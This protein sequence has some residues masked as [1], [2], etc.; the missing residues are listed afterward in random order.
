MALA[1]VLIAS[2]HIDQ[3]QAYNGRPASLPLDV[4][5][6]PTFDTRYPKAPSTLFLP[7][8]CAHA[9]GT[10]STTLRATQREN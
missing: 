6:G 7:N 3:A 9:H 1:H 10:A 8:A 5:R 4:A 2:P